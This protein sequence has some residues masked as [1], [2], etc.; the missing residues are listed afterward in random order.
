MINRRK[1]FLT[2]LVV[3]GLVLPIKSAQ[4]ACTLRGASI[5]FGTYDPISL[6]PLDT[7]GAVIYRCAGSDHNITITLSRGGGATFATRRMIK[8][9]EQLFYNLYR[10][11]A[12]T[13]IWGDGT[14]GTQSFFIGNPQANNTDLS[15]PIFGRIPAGQNVSKGSF[16]DTIT[17]TLIF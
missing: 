12:R 1:L 13:A 7:A 10:D 6:T 14:G 17:V 9:S 4:A 5:A 2:V 15:V 11:A 8:G 16:S 3:L